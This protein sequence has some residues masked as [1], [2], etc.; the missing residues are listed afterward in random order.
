MHIDSLT[1]TALVVFIIMLAVF[2]R[3]CRV[4]VCGMAA[5]RMHD[6]QDKAQGGGKS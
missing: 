6:T 4:K 1:V 3:F 5:T 2:V